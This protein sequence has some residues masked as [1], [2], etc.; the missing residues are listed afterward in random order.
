MFQ[1]KWA[2]IA[3]SVG[4]LFG[5]LNPFVLSRVYNVF[6][7][8]CSMN[9]Y[10]LLQFSWRDFQLMSW[11]FWWRLLRGILDH[12]RLDQI[13]LE[14]YVLFTQFGRLAEQFACCSISNV[15]KA[16]MQPS[17]CVVNTCLLLCLACMAYLPA[18][19]VSV[20][21]NLFLQ[22]TFPLSLQSGC[23]TQISFLHSPYQW[24]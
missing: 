1:N 4:N 21:V 19:C 3:P 6:D 15:Y 16:L 10:V 18:A 8:T 9:F 2:C 13:R 5:W 17:I 20:G 23:T 12:L 22:K 11:A 14:L 7:L 24:S